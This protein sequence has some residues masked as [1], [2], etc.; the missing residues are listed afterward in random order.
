MPISEADLAMAA[1]T[2]ETVAVNPVSDGA[3][4]YQ[5]ITETANDLIRSFIE[6]TPYFVAALIVIIIFWLLSIVFKKALNTAGID[7]P[8][9]VRTLDLSHPSV[10]AIAKQI[11]EQQAAH[12]DSLGVD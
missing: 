3:L 12:V 9:P 8:F 1:T 5:T 10:K 4:T 2:N 11:H 7:M 6:R